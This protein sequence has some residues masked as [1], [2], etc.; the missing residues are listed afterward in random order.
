MSQFGSRQAQ[1][2]LQSTH[3]CSDFFFLFL[4]VFRLIATG[5]GCIM[6]D[7]SCQSSLLFYKAAIKLLP[8]HVPEVSDCFHRAPRQT[9]G[10]NVSLNS[11]VT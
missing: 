6:P 10:G 1:Q 4:F 8:V 3:P 2:A 5:H 11:T 9:R 7:Y